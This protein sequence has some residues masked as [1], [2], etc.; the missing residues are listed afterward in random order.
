MCD[1]SFLVGRCFD[2]VTAAPG[3]QQQ[4]TGCLIQ[5]TGEELPLVPW[6]PTPGLSTGAKLVMMGRHRVT[7]VMKNST[8]G[9]GGASASV[10]IHWKKGPN[11]SS[12]LW[13]KA[14]SFAFLVWKLWLKEKG[15]NTEIFWGDSPFF[16]YFIFEHQPIRAQLYIKSY[17]FISGFD[18]CEKR[19]SDEWDHETFLWSSI[20]T[21]KPCVVKALP[22]A[23]ISLFLCVWDLK[24]IITLECF[25]VLS[26]TSPPR[27]GGFSYFWWRLTSSWEVTCMNG[28]TNIGSN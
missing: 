6:K 12:S 16:S 18:E 19:W 13:L 10:F 17:H 9:D 4:I 8:G 26:A 1:T 22:Q 2:D 21:L 14:F 11:S 23:Q 27:P 20:E 24:K 28:V 25:S 5:C 7:A 15:S 3:K